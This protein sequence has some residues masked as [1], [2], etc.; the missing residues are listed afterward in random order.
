MHFTKHS[1]LAGK[2]AFL[3]ASKPYWLRYDN[4]DLSKFDRA[5]I[6]SLQAQRG[7]EL[8][9]LAHQMIKL[10]VKLP[11]NGE[12]LSMYVNDAIEL[13]LHPEVLLYYSD[14]AFG[15]PDAINFETENNL[16]R[17]HD[18]KS[19][20]LEAKIDQ[21]MVY[22]GLFCLEYLAKPMHITAE[23]RVYQN[24][25]ANIYKPTPDELIHVIE[26]ITAFDKRINYLKRR[27][28]L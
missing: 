16:L 28:G 11:D 27:E 26:R 18:L 1:G 14:N 8:H 5:Y 13:G 17:I 25:Q 19:G 6:A 4:D 12:T 2:H 22:A 3:S 21:L 15:T 7:T 10:G 9:A 23:L 20:V 24:N